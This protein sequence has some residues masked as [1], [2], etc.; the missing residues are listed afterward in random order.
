MP[1]EFLNEVVIRPAETAD[2]AFLLGL[3]P[4]LAAFPLPP[5]RRSGRHWRGLTA[6]MGWPTDVSPQAIVIAFAIAAVL[7][8]AFGY[9]PA[10]RASLLDPIVALRRE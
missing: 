5:D 10:R 9:Y 3:T 6:R 2:E 1:I 4:Q 8:V 7:G